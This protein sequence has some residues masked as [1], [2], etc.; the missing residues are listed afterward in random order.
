M[1]H[2][3]HVPGCKKAVPPHLLMCLKHWTSV[4]KHL[5]NR[6]WKTY[7]R[8]QEVDKKPSPEYLAAAQAAINAALEAQPQKMLV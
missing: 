5:R 7:R 2:H 4:P 1:T 6:V 3:C 8:G